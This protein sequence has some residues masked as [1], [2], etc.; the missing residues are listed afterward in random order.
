MRGAIQ[1]QTIDVPP[2]SLRAAIASVDE[3]KRTVDLIFS[4]GAP[5]LRYDW[6][7]GQKFFEQL[8]ITS[9][10]VR[11]DR[12]NVA[13][14]LLDAH[15]AYSVYD[16][17]GA[18]VEGTA[19]IEKGQARC[20]VVFSSRDAVTP[21]WNDVI[22][23]PPI[24]RS[25][26]VGYRVYAFEEKT[27]T[28]GTIPTRTA[29]DWEPYEISMVPMPADVGAKARDGDKSNMNAC[30]I[31]R[32]IVGLPDADRLRRFRLAMARH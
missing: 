13:G 17:L 18:V 6:M 3:R 24:I 15:S 29:T 22:S 11:L 19:K 26:S 16:Q 1:P 32:A 9:K 4:T 12:L 23:D 8:A 25:V 30:V 14:P 21:I 31:T 7:S 10:A 2:L 20:T 27:G 28:D 5:V